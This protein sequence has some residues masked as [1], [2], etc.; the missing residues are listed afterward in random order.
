MELT[1]GNILDINDNIQKI[2]MNLSDVIMSDGK[3]LESWLNS[4]KIKY[5]YII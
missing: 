4:D 3:T 2:N 1:L 5:I